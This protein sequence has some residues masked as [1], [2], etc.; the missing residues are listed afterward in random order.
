M[1]DYRELDA[2]AKAPDRVSDLAKYL[3]K[4]AGMEWTDWELDFLDDR[5]QCR[6]PLSTRQAEVLIELRDEAIFY[7]KVDGFSLSLLLN[8]CWLNRHDLPEHDE[9]CI[10]RLR[11]TGANAF[12]KRDAQHILRCARKIG[13]IEP[14]Q[15]WTFHPPPLKAA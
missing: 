9:Q 10:S 13:E 1:T 8:A 12:R 15:G 14:H 11:E 5:T 6:E 3:L 7:S 4:Q 2:L